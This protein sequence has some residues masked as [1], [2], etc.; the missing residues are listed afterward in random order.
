MFKI[1]ISILDYF[2]FSFGGG[3]GSENLGMKVFVDIFGVTSII[4]FFMFF[5]LLKSTTGI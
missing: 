5:F 1:C 4:K 3:E 2:P